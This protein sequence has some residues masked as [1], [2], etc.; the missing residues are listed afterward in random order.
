M[1]LKNVANFMALT[2]RLIEREPHLPGFGVCHGPS[3]YGKTYAS[4]YAQNRTRAVRVEVGESWTRKTFLKSLLFE[5]GVQARG[6]ISDMADQAKALL[7]DDPRRPLIVDEADKLVDKG[8]VELVREIGDVAGC[9]VILIGEERL[10]AKLVQHERIHN[11]VLDWM[12]AQPCDLD[13]TTALARALC[14]RVSVAAD[15]LDDIRRQSEGRARRIVVNL[16]R[17]GELAR[18][19]GLTAV[20]RAAWGGTAFYTSRAPAPRTVDA[21][22]W[23]A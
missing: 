22:R 3:G 10:P 14:P 18:N 20:D 7:G 4:I 11:R 17:V 9:P 1:P 23:S 8:M 13:D 6:T 15:L 2:M 16:S 19:R 5:L 12:P 21:G